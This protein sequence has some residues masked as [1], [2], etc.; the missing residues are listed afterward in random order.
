MENTETELKQVKRNWRL[1]QLENK[2][3]KAKLKGKD[4]QIGKL[5]RRQKLNT[6]NTLITKLRKQIEELSEDLQDVRCD[7]N[8]IVGKLEDIVD[9][10][11]YEVEK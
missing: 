7:Y 1:V 11:T 3:L 8:R 5:K 2:M 10:G 6:Q 4:A 9:E